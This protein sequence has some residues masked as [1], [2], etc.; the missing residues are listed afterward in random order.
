VCWEVWSAIVLKTIGLILKNKLISIAKQLRPARLSKLASYLLKDEAIS[1]KLIIG[2]TI[3]ALIAANTALSSTYSSFLHVNLSLGIGDW[4]LSK[5][6]QHWIDE[7]LMAVFFL[8]VGLELKRELVRGEL[9]KLKTAT[10]PFA[11][12]IGGMVIPALIYMSLNAGQDSF[13]GWAI[14][15]ATDI[16]FAIGILALLGKRIPSS[17]RLFLLTLAIVDD[18][19]AVIVIAMF[20][21]TGINPTMLLLAALMG[22]LMLLLRKSK[23][24]TMPVFVIAAIAL[25][26]V[27][28]ASG[29]QPSIAGAIVGL[30]APITAI[31]LRTESIAERLERFTIPL[32]TLLIVPLFAFANT[33]IILSLSSFQNDSAL[34][35]AGGIILGLV[36]GKILGI[37]GAS[38]LVVKLRY[39]DLPLEANW[40]HIVGVGFLAGIGFTVAIFVTELAFTPDEYVTIAKISIFAASIISGLIGLVFLLR[41]NKPA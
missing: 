17:I 35:I 21:G 6:L 2:A 24:L 4:V 19:G 41:H 7:G 23:F 36:V 15:M 30:L 20:Y 1:G 27:I 3:L 34:P 28:D 40:N 5:D 10:L 33:G 14:P 11:A 39:A 26:L 8:V 13:K 18:I 31:S 22:V 37:V 9:R 38:W 12:A 16:A 32:S 25:W 29:V